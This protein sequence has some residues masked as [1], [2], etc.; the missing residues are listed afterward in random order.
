MGERE[1]ERKGGKKVG[2]RREGGK[3]GMKGL[4]VILGFSS[5]I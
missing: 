5:K 2:E 4:Y 3:E 1:E